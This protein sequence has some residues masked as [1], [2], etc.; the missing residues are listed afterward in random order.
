MKNYRFLA[1][2]L[3][4]LGIVS[5]EP[6]LD[7]PIDETGDVYA[8]GE[9]DFTHYVALGNSLTAGYADNALYITGQTNSY[10][11]I[12]AGQFALTQETDEFTI[13][14]MN[15]NAGG[16]LLSGDPLPGFNNRLVLAVDEDGERAPSVYT[17]MTATTDIAN[18][19]EGPF[20]NMGVPG[21]KSYHLGVNGYGNIAGLPS[22]MANPYFVRFAS[23]PQASIIEDAMA[24]NPSFFTLWIGNNDVLG[25]ASSGGTGVNQAGNFNPATYGSNDITDPMVFAQVYSDLVQTLISG[26]A[27]GVLINIPDVTDVAFFN[28]VPF[29]AL[30][31]ATNDDFAAQ[32]PTLNATFSQL[33]QVFAAL[34]V[35]DRSIQYSETAASPVLIFD[36]S[37]TNLSAQI[38][39]VLT[40]SGFD[41][42]MAALYGQQFGQVRQA[43]SEDLFT[44]TSSRVIGQLNETRFAQLVQAGVPQEMAG[45][46]AINGITYPLGD[47]YVL[48]PSEQT[49]IL[50][51]TNAFNTSI[52]SIAT[53]NNLA[54]V[55]ANA[56][57]SQVANGGIAFD[58]GSVNSTFGTGGAF[59]LDGV[60]LTPRGYAIVAN[61]I[62]DQINATYGATVPKVNVGQYG[63][64]T[65][66]N[67]VQ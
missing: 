61:E 55:D 42:S 45:Q 37:L 59:S 1:V 48:I 3:L 34:Q 23:S 52:E 20:S 46:L 31:P 21:A 41:A 9:A 15:D 30:N 12:L 32:I 39:Q 63:T 40:Q 65:L 13:P 57:L 66:S 19:L 27:N 44:L 50:E 64:I 47:E 29:N 36:E 5:C 14:Y 24:Q 38:T 49:E 33:N 28:T 54:F 25:Y 26:G 58:G 11:N 18:I 35:S 7:N 2:G 16:L 6:D 8:N 4:A 60:H 17:G 67:E 10:P 56:M 51:A 22:G 43:T 53:S 62:I